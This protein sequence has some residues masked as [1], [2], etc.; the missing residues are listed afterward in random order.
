MRTFIFRGREGHIKG[1]KKK[2]KTHT[3][4]NNGGCKY[5]ARPP[6]STDF[7]RLYDSCTAAVLSISHTAPRPDDCVIVPV[8]PDAS[9]EQRPLSGRIL[10]GAS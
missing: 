10:G 9:R 1:V 6:Q 4:S 7:I 3:T 2:K 5:S 8:E